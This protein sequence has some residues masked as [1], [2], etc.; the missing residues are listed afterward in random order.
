MNKKVFNSLQ[1]FG[2][3]WHKEHGTDVNTMIAAKIPERLVVKTEKIG[4]YESAYSYVDNLFHKVGIKAG[5]VPAED[6]ALIM[7]SIRGGR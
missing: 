5:R 2:V 3:E 1:E 6:F 4:T 7:E